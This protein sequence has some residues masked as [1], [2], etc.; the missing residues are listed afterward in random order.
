MLTNG[1]HW[2]LYYKGALSV[3]EDFHEID[4]GKALG[5]AGC[6]PDLLDTRPA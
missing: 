5:L 1:R 6:E 3:A 4:L 2:R